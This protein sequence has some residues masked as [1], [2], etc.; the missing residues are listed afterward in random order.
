[1]TSQTQTETVALDPTTVTTNNVTVCEPHDNSDWD[2]NFTPDLR[3]LVPDRRP[4][5]SRCP[6][7]R[8]LDGANDGGT[9]SQSIEETGKRSLHHFPRS[10]VTFPMPA[11]EFD[12]RVAVTLNQ[13]PSRFEGRENKE[14]ISIVAGLWS[15]SFGNGRITAG[16]YD[17]GQA[18]GFR[19]VR[20]VEAA[21]NLQTMDELPASLEMRT[22]GSLSGP[23][24]VLDTLLNP[25]QPKNIDP[26]RYS[27]RMFATLK[28]PD[29]RYA[30]IVNCGLWVASGVWHDRELIIE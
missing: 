11:L 2:T 30:E 20:I 5:E 21:F 9:Q 1:M 15:G 8:G 3:L 26:R 22:R 29:K 7:K 17:L 18:R 13:E 19:P 25:S 4:S 10:A 12:F 14:I 16:G 27:L 6:A 28:S 24:D 23:C